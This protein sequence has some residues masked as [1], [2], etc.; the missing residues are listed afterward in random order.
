VTD[1]DLRDTAVAFRTHLLEML[2]TFASPDEQ[3]AYGRAV[4][5]VPVPAELMCGWTDDLYH[6]DSPAH[7]LAFSPAERAA[8][9]GFDAEFRR[10]ATQACGGDLEM[11]IT[12]ASGVALARAATI[13]L[14]A[15]AAA[16][17]AEPT[18]A[19]DGGGG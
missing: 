19:A 4:P 2:R 18:A 10:C 14:T 13:A 8:L 12:S 3:R 1:A 6:P 11:F 15:F 17:D 7:A 5:F 16:P 9:A